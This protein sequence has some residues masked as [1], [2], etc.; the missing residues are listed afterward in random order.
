MKKSIILV[1]MLA[2]AMAGSAQSNIL[3]ISHEWLKMV[4]YSYQPGYPYGFS[5]A[6]GSFLSLGFA[7]DGKRYYISA[8]EYRE[9]TWSLRCGW[10][11]YNFD[12]DITGWGAVSFRPMLVMGI[13]KTKDVTTE[14]GTN[15]V[16]ESN[17]YFTLAPSI[18]VNVYM[19]HFSLGYEIVPKFKEL[20]GLNFGIGFSIPYNRDKATEKVQ[21]WADERKAVRR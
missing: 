21:K 16:K 15:W 1:V 9:P 2:A 17:T 6:G 13:D 11:G 14:D 12:K 4:G 19:V 8:T 18:V 5:L 20:N 7:E 3:N 10:I